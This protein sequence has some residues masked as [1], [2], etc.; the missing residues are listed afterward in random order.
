MNKCPFCGKEIQSKAIK[1]WHCKEWLNQKKAEEI[2]KTASEE[3]S[4]EKE[5]I[6]INPKPTHQNKRMLNFLI[7]IL[8]LE[9]NY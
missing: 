5:Y 6:V 1:C 3:S 9:R 2:K 8:L 4:F 7:D